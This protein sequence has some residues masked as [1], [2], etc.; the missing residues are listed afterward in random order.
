[1]TLGK[2]IA[3]ILLFGLLL[4]TSGSVHAQRLDAKALMRAQRN[5]QGNLYGSN[6]YEQQQDDE[7]QPADTT[8]QER[9]IR[10]P[11]ESY[12]FDDSIRAM[13]N[14]VWHARKDFNR[15]EMADRKSV[16]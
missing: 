1:M 9:R 7:E 12:F 6:P 2:K 10:K 3:N 5:G 16:V 8:K 14:F 4:A 13:S 15:V 11:L